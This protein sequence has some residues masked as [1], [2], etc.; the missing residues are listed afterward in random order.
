[1]KKSYFSVIFQLIRKDLIAFRRSYL[2]KA[3]DTF[4]LL[5][6]NLIVFG[7]FMPHLGLSSDYGVFLLIGAVTTFGFFDIVGK[8]STLVEDMQG[9]KTISYLLTLPI[10]SYFIFIY[11]GLNWAMNSALMSLIIFPMGKFL[12]WSQVDFSSFS[13]FKLAIIYILINLFFGYFSLWV[14][15]MFKSMSDLGHL[16]LRVINPIFMF[17]GYFFSWKA[18]FAF[19]P[20]VSTLLLFN[21][22]IY[23]TE[24]MRSATLN[25]ADYLPF[26]ASALALLLF[27]LFFA[28]HGTRRMLQRLDCVK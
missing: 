27:T 9:D 17:G 4:L 22:M 15:S 24:G 13:Y 19:S 2:S 12:L 25:P 7:Y 10:P 23:A 3:V 1:M 5:V 26:T 16:W 18:V 21:P 11:I 6:T 20:F 8:I 28:W 14:A